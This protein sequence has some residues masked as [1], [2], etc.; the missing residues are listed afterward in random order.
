MKCE[1]AIHDW[2]T[3]DEDEDDFG[4]Y[5]SDDAE[6]TN[7]WV[8]DVDLPIEE[9][10]EMTEEEIVATILSVIMMSG[11]WMLPPDNDHGINGHYLESKHEEFNKAFSNAHP[12]LQSIYCFDSFS[13]R[14]EHD[15]C[16]N[17]WHIVR[18]KSP[19]DYEWLGQGSSFCEDKLIND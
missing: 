5:R 10:R 17:G 3:Y 14:L 12:I 13:E 19:G 6:F 1:V 7:L 11:H 9:M 8:T 4:C 16:L 15:V 2:F 18:E